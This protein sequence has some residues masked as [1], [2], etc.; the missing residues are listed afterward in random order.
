MPRVEDV[1]E[2]Q[3]AS[4]SGP[5]EKVKLVR[6]A[7]PAT[8]LTPTLQQTLDEWNRKSDK[9]LGLISNVLAYGFRFT[10]PREHSNLIRLIKGGKLR[11]CRVHAPPLDGSNA[12]SSSP[13][14]DR[15][16]ILRE[17]CPTKVSEGQISGLKRKR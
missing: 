10:K 5:G 13:Y 11:L 9:S 6:D 1:T 14:S 16:Y 12:K 2:E 7:K 15:Y 17:S 3:I 4:V 8:K